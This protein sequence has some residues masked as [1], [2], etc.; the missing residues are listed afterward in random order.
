MR[1]VYPRS[2]AVPPYRPLGTNVRPLQSPPNIM[3]HI[4][5]PLPVYRRLPITTYMPSYRPPSV[6]VGGNIRPIY[7]PSNTARLPSYYQ[8]IIPWGGRTVTFPPMFPNYPP[9]PTG[10][11]IPILNFNPLPQG[12]VNAVSRYPYPQIGQVQVPYRPVLNLQLWRPQYSIGSAPSI[13]G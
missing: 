2:P 4:L 12:A 11:R 6:A 10:T 5:G 7:K 1:P 13:T 9:R 3:G 8:R